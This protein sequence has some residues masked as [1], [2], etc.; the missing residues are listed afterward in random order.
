ME[1]KTQ[2]NNILLATFCFAAVFVIFGGIGFLT[3]GRTPDTI[4][5]GGG[6]CE[7][8]G[9]GKVPRRILAIPVEEGG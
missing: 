6:G 2:H 7:Y 8:R 5:G 4:K 3:F 1:K 9:S